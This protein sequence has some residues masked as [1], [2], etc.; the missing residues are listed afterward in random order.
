MPGPSTGPRPSGWETSVYTR[1][2]TF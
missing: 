1:G 2:W